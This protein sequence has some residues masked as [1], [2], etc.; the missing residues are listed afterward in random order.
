MLHPIRAQGSSCSPT[1]RFHYVSN[2][3]EEFLHATWI[4]SLAACPISSASAGRAP[5]PPSLQ[6]IA[7]KVW[8]YASTLSQLCSNDAQIRVSWRLESQ[9]SKLNG[10]F[11]GFIIK[12]KTKKNSKIERSY[13][14][15]KYWGPF[16]FF[17]KVWV[18][19]MK[20]YSGVNVE[21]LSHE[22]LNNII[23]INNVLCG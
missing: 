6:P 21:F 15:T 12:F 14:S 17:P 13:W 7:L 23:P 18:Y 10:V 16:E 11:I 20:N 3:V 2:W 8:N 4:P 5:W 19:G 22:I 9:L 1:D